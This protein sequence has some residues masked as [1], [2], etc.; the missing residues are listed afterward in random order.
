MINTSIQ[1]K[2]GSLRIEV[3]TNDDELLR[4]IHSEYSLISERKKTDIVLQIKKTK[5]V[6]V[7]KIKF[8]NKT[9][10]I[11]LCRPTMVQYRE[12]LIQGLLAIALLHWSFFL[13]HASS[14]L[15]KNTLHVFLGKSGSGKTTILNSLLRD[16]ESIAVS[17]DTLIGQLDENESLCFY[18]SIFDKEFDIKLKKYRP[19]KIYLYTLV[20]SKNN[21]TSEVK[22]YQK[23]EL[24]LLNMYSYML[25]AQENVLVDKLRI[26]YKTKS[27][28]QALEIIK[29]TQIVQLMFNKRISVHHLPS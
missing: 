14:V 29:K 13:F 1:F 27:Y 25:A 19:K 11:R 18:G 26:A 12:F 20:Q 17:N 10:T 4:F 28:L 8:Q 16:K 3:Q 24:V 9:N 15:V 2:I 5:N 6:S 23:I 21:L 22:Q 7:W